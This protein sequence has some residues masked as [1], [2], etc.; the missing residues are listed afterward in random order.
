MWEYRKVHLGKT[1][2]W[3]G[4]YQERGGGLALVKN[5]FFK[6]FTRFEIIN[7]TEKYFSVYLNHI[8]EN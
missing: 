4:D 3:G 5:K 1:A 6:T 2:K 7:C 8:L